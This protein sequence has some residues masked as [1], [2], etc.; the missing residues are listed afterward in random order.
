MAR[1][2]AQVVVNDLDP[3]RVTQVA[4]DLGAEGVKAASD[5]L[6]VTDD[7]AIKAAIDGTV[8][9]YGR[10]DVL[11]SHAGFQIE[12][13]LEQVPLEGMDMSWRLNVRA[14][15]VAARAAVRHMRAQGGAASS[16]P[17]RIPV[18]NM[19]AG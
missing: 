9:T 17:R 13:N 19:I 15:F 6:D 8:A 7:A 11:H 12:G 2:G 18:C 14:H 1:H 5:G 4:E 10:L 3:V 16:S